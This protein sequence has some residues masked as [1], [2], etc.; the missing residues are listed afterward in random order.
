MNMKSK[1]LP[2]LA[3]LAAC[4]S[5]LPA[6]AA[7]T[8]YGRTWKGDEVLTLMAEGQQASST[9]P[10]TYT[11]S[12]DCPTGWKVG[13]VYH[14][15]DLRYADH[16]ESFWLQTA[17]ANGLI[18][19]ATYTLSGTTLTIPYK[20]GF[21]S[22]AVRYVPVNY[23]IEFDANASDA[24]GKT[25]GL[26]NISYTNTTTK[27]TTCGFERTGYS[28][29]GWTLN[30][31]GTGTVFADQSAVDGEKFGVTTDGQ[32]I[33]LYAKWSAHS[34]EVTCSADGGAFSDGTSS[35]SKSLDYDS[36]FSVSAPTKTGYT[37]TGWMVSGHNS[38]T[39]EWGT[40]SDCSSS[41]PNDDYV[42]TSDTAYFKNLAT[43]STATV[44][45]KALW[46]A[47]KT[48][49][50]FSRE[51][52]TGGTGSIDG[53][54]YGTSKDG[55]AT[56]EPPT[57]AGE[58]F[59]GY[60]T[61]TNGGGIKYFDANG[62]LLRNWD[63]SQT[64]VTLYANWSADT[65]T[66][67]FDANGGSG[68][69]SDLSV[70]YSETFTLPP[71]DGLTHADAYRSFA[72]WSRSANGAV[73]FAAG[74][75]TSF[76]ANKAYETSG[77]LT[78]Y[79]VWQDNRKSVSV[80]A[81]NYGTAS[82]TSIS[83]IP[84]QPY[85]ELP[86][87]TPK[88]YKKAFAGWFT[89]AT[90]GDQILATDIVPTI[91]PQTIYA[92]WTNTWYTIRFNGNDNT[93]GTMADQ[94]V[95]FNVST[96]LL[97][98]SFKRTGYTFLGWAKT[99]D[100][101]KADYANDASV[102]DLASAA[103]ATVDLYAVWTANTYYVEFAPNGGSG[104]MLTLTNKYDVSFV[105]PACAFTAPAFSTFGGWLDAANSKTYAA[106]ET[107]KNLTAAG[108]ATVTLT[109]I[110][111]ST[112]SD[113]SKAMHCTNLVWSNLYAQSTIKWTPSE[114]GGYKSE[115][116]SCARQEN[117]KKA[118]RSP[119][120]ARMVGTTTD[121]N[122]GVAGTLSFWWKPSC[123]E[124]KLCWG[125]SADGGYPSAADLSSVSASGTA[126]T[127]VSIVVSSKMNVCYFILDNLTDVND[128]G[129]TYE[130]IDQMTWTTAD[131]E[132]EHP[133]P[134]EDDAVTI[135]GLT[136]TDG[137]FTLSYTGDE[138]FAYRVL[139]TDS[140]ASPIT[141]QPYGSLTNDMG[142]SGSQTF[143]LDRD[144]SVPMRFFKVETIRRP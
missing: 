70:K 26:S 34:Y 20:A 83:V 2:L 11:I 144:A 16:V 46:S 136:A 37:F 60:Y 1:I 56:I 90:D 118:S 91:Y 18:A 99:A 51:G 142:A 139:Y 98:N 134:T 93:S 15:K 50:T 63:I 36:A 119:M 137:G 108:G 43:S 130:C 10:I 138:K 112:L 87:V 77:K 73:D 7:T 13:N 79:A 94:A 111:N 133:E 100:A 27:L 104:T 89:E 120:V 128:D 57:K 41:I 125:I 82:Q 115:S 92:H 97:E 59:L 53:I 40:T 143:T 105:L 28:F 44:T 66:V 126:W 109:A 69:I 29:G 76:S 88:S 61:K 95:E 25:D 14:A 39:A 58:T 55:Y 75:E 64:E 31:A 124:A 32:T 19:D 110:W 80:E 74:A 67:A 33:T 24:T 140:L 85:G 101:A 71:G 9:S 84:G 54:A 123:A 72:G 48:K 21:E 86:T 68:T 78:F 4:A 122:A 129:V 12:D 8:V 47:I 65:Y 103:N 35:Y 23:S 81:G 107:V 127:K 102:T 45:L 113:L 42:K 30:K 114:T 38:S 121:M 6:T 52:G 5:A 117:G 135:S 116:D 17:Y 141:W 62:Y 132:E 49:V 22:F 106:G 3:G 131:A 96:A